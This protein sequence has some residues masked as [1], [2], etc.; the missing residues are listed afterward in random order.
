ML[1]IPAVEP[2]SAHELDPLVTTLAGTGTSVVTENSGAT[3]VLKATGPPEVEQL[4]DGMMEAGNGQMVTSDG[5]GL[6]G[7]IMVASTDSTVEPCSDVIKL[8][9][10]EVGSKS[11]VA[12][13]GVPVECGI[14]FVVDT[15]CPVRTG[16]GVDDRSEL[17]G[18]QRVRTSGDW[19]GLADV[20]FPPELESGEGQRGSGS[21]VLDINEVRLERGGR[22]AENVDVGTTGTN[23][24]VDA[25]AV[26]KLGL[27]MTVSPV[28]NTKTV[29]E[30][31]P[32]G[33]V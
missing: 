5:E 9:G 12:V 11:V 24:E 21:D 23:A 26:N 28:V 14:K 27:P 19:V 20:R 15:D 2:V 3:V 8:T 16:T 31:C 22:L 7:W 30:P 4:A 6:L 29:E 25:G 13:H 10:V 1:P 33:T 32:S 17:A 18:G